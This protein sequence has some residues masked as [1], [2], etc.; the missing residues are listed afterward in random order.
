MRNVPIHCIM[1]PCR[2]CHSLSRKSLVPVWRRTAFACSVRDSCIRWMLRIG[3]CLWL[4]CWWCC[5]MA[6][7]L[8]DAAYLDTCI[9]P[10][11]HARDGKLWLFQCGSGWRRIFQSYSINIFG[12]STSWPLPPPDMHRAMP[13]AKRW[14]HS[15]KGYKSQGRWDEGHSAKSE[16]YC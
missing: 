16:S 8:G 13:W 1:Q 7:D 9:H 2:R 15:V 5:T 3:G 11:R 14:C 4:L 6:M 12:L 10:S